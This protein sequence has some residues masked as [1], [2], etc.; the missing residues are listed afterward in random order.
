[1][2]FLPHFVTALSTKAAIALA[3]VGLA[4]GGATAGVVVTGSPNPAVWGQQVVQF[5]AGCQATYP[6][7]ANSSTTPTSS[8]MNV[9]RCVSAQA[10]QK[11]AAER[12]A[13]SMASSAPN[14]RAAGKPAV[15]GSQ[16]S[17]PSTGKP[18]SV[19]AGSGASQGH[20]KPQ[21]LPIPNSAP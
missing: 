4:A 19:P 12:K 7:G 17:S 21:G 13:H 18:A 1:M 9:G 5:V 14:S 8:S 6:P 11:G 10:N 20:G 15:P 16:G 2:S 3:A